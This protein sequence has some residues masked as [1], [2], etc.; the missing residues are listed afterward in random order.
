[1]MIHKFFALTFVMLSLNGCGKW[2]NDAYY[3][4]D[5][6]QTRDWAAH[7]PVYHPRTVYCYKSL[8]GANC[9]NEP[10]LGRDNQ[11]IDAYEPAPIVKKENTN[12]VDD[13][14]IEMKPLP[15]K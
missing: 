5:R 2:L 14:V 10:Q 1:M 9:Y 4:S 8:A 3:T 6:L 7:G 15:L 11:L 13:N 12:L